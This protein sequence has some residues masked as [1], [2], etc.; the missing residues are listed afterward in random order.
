MKL[1]QNN[2]KLILGIM[3]DRHISFLWNKDKIYKYNI[4]GFP[5]KNSS[6]AKGKNV[7]NNQHNF[8]HMKKLT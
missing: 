5:K 1:C 8:S 3:L 2:L 6:L 7:G 4:K